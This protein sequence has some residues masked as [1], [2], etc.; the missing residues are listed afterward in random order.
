MLGDPSG[1]S[2]RAA[3]GVPY[4]TVIPKSITSGYRAITSILVPG[5]PKAPTSPHFP[6]PFPT[7]RSPLAALFR[8][9]KRKLNLS[10]TFLGRA[11]AGYLNLAAI[12]AALNSIPVAN[13]L[14]LEH[15]MEVA[16]ARSQS[17]R[18]TTTAEKAFFTDRSSPIGCA[19]TASCGACPRHRF[20]LDASA[21]RTVRANGC[22]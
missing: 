17:S 19:R 5:I 3:D 12:A 15:R 10:S 13:G 8:R 18:T 6:R 2:N 20:T 9:A 1:R 21:E 16:G 14:E 22:E 7:T 4:A 11:T